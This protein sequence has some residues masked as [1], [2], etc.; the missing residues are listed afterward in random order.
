MSRDDDVGQ[1]DHFAEVREEDVVGKFLRDEDAG[2]EDAC[3][4]GVDLQDGSRDVV[5]G[6]DFFYALRLLEKRAECVGPALDVVSEGILFNVEE[7]GNFE[8]A[9]VRVYA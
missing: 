6:S 5:L 3:C 1:V 8:G 7:G 9:A 2:D 4:E